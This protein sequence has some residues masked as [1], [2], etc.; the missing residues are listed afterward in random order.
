MSRLALALLSVCAIAVVAPAGAS[1][2]LYVSS[3]KNPGTGG[4]GITGMVQL[5]DGGGELLRN[6]SGGSAIAGTGGGPIVYNSGGTGSIKQLSGNSYVTL[7]TGVGGGI[8]S[9]SLTG[10][11][12]VVANVNK[13]QYLNRPSGTLT[14]VPH[15]TISDGPWVSIT[16]QPNGL[17]LGW[18]WNNGW[19]SL[20][21]LNLSSGATTK[22]DFT[23]QVNDPLFNNRAN[24]G[25]LYGSGPVPNSGGISADAQGG[26]WLANGGN[27][28][29]FDSARVYYAAP[30]GSF[31]E[32]GSNFNR[33][34]ISATG[35]GKAY[36]SHTYDS[37][38]EGHVYKFTPSGNQG[39]VTST[40]STGKLKD[41]FIEGLAV[42]RCYTFCAVSPPTVVNPGATNTQKL[43]TPKKSIKLG[44]KGLKLKLK[45]SLACTITITGR[46][47]FGKV[48]SAAGVKLKK[49]KFKLKAGKA[50]TVTVKMSKKQRAKVKRA[51]RQKR[52]VVAKLKLVVASKGVKTVRKPLKL[53]VK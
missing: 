49:A 43:T 48:N 5:S 12:L 44:K 9:M 10:R 24:G 27:I 15:G 37:P 3:Q 34:H 30:N 31:N 17:L 50:K 1:A 45:C 29:N 53:R 21:E 11:G 35:D 2:Q 40:A 52:K 16:T 32:I 33:P 23:G 28:G 19:G 26:I 42:D 22:Q 20:Y 14:D 8:R 46:L 4:A 51:R 13:L 7:A 6:G 39:E 25:L 38:N 47:T 41:S 36:V 18:A